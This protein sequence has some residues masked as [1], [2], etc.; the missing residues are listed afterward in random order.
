MTPS[1]ALDHDVG[2]VG[3]AD[4][5]GED[6][7]G[8]FDGVDSDIYGLYVGGG[9]GVLDHND[10]ADPKTIRRLSSHLQRCARS[11][12]F[13]S[14]RQP[15][16]AFA[17][18]RTTNVCSTVV[19]INNIYMVG[20]STTAWMM[21]VPTFDAVRDLR[22]FFNPRQLQPTVASARST[23]TT[24]GCPTVLTVNNTIAKMSWD[25]CSD[26]CNDNVG[27]QDIVWA[28]ARQHLD[29]QN[30]LSHRRV[31]KQLLD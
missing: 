17:S 8:T 15:Q 3:T 21:F 12:L 23:G 7:Y 16:L 5:M 29:E 27:R 28:S 2:G 6:V 13:S 31:L 11:T 10:I 26:S 9:S 22:T 1:Q 25:G 4:F 18:A 19:G 24:N 30:A 14:P 20:A